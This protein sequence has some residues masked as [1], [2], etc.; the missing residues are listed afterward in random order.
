MHGKEGHSQIYGLNR[1]EGGGNGAQGAAAGS[2]GAVHK[3][4]IGNSFRLA[5]LLQNR[6]RL[7]VGGIGL[8]AGLLD[9]DALP[10]NILLSALLG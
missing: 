1:K 2:V 7:A 3:L 5:E 6:H 4:L 8:A 10:Q 9:A